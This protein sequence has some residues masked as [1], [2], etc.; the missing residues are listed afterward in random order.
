M[1]FVTF[2]KCWDVAYGIPYPMQASYVSLPQ[3]NF[4]LSKS[5]WLRLPQKV[6]LES[7]FSQ[8]K[9]QTLAIFQRFHKNWSCRRSGFLEKHFQVF[10]A[11]Q[12][13][14]GGARGRVWWWNALQLASF[15]YDF[16]KWLFFSFPAVTSP[17]RAT[18]GLSSGASGQ[19]QFSFLWNK[20]S[21][22]KVSSFKAAETII[23]ILLAIALKSVVQK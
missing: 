13:Q 10:Y 2:H 3:N 14:F 1:L 12:P 20:P 9:T 5:F 18:R 15:F 22:I 23:S 8:R 7:A 4:A 21:L 19:F 17:M 6:C 16:N 11:Q